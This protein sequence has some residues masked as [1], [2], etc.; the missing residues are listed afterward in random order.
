MQKF[1]QHGVHTAQVL[2]THVFDTVAA[3]ILIAEQGAQDEYAISAKEVHSLLEL[4]DMFGLESDFKAATKS[5]R[6][7][8]AEDTSKLEALGWIQR[9]TLVEYIDS[10]KR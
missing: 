6:S 4:R 7:T 9:H 3:L 2:F 1:Q 8:G 10:C 5:T